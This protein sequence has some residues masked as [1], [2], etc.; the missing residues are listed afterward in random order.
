M[1]ALL[2][3]LC[4]I[5]AACATSATPNSFASYGVTT[6]QQAAA[7]VLMWRAEARLYWQDADRLEREAAFLSAEGP[8]RN[9]DRVAQKLAMAKGLRASGDT[10]ASRATDLQAL[11]PVK[12]IQ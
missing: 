6:Q 12:M 3:L 7:L 9:A 1:A 4:L 10:L 11:L 2:G 8:E 5:L